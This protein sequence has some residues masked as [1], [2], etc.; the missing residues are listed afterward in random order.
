MGHTMNTRIILCL[1]FFILTTRAFK[2]KKCEHDKI[3]TAVTS[4]SKCTVNAIKPTNR[5]LAMKAEDDV[6]ENVTDQTC[7]L[8]KKDGPIMTCAKENL[9]EC[10]ETHDLE[11]LKLAGQHARLLSMQPNCDNDDTQMEVEDDMFFAWLDLEGL[12]MDEDL[13]KDTKDVKKAKEQATNDVMKCFNATENLC[14]S[15]REMTYMRKDFMET[16]EDIMSSMYNIGVLN[17]DDE[18]DHSSP[19]MSRDSGRNFE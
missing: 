5:S 16:F 3:I 15:E 2:S 11:Y 1:I 18:K 13:I 4:Y 9:G 19:P 8:L 14:F 17:M 10:F 7:T 6:G 12:N